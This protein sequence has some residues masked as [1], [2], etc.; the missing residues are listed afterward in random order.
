M[1]CSDCGAPVDMHDF[2]DHIRLGIC[3][4]S[5]LPHALS[6]MA[7]VADDGHLEAFLVHAAGAGFALTKLD[8][9]ADRTITLTLTYFPK[10][11][12]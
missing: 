7:A 12:S 8:S 6:D 4:C 3:P 2:G 9:A 11:P 1:N 10:E 5:D